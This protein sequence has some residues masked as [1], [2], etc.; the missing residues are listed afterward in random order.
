MRPVI[1]LINKCFNRHIA[2]EKQYYHELVTR[3]KD[4]MKIS[5]EIRKYIINKNKDPVR[6]TTFKLSDGSTTTDEMSVS[7]H[8]NDIFIN[9]CP[10]LTKSIPH[11]KKCL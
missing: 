2:A 8:F 10:N 3:N 4:N 6:R 11:V 5:W 9:I 7:E 1:N